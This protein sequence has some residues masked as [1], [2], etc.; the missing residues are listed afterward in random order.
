MRRTVKTKGQY[1]GGLLA[2]WRSAHGD[3]SAGCCPGRIGIN[4]NVDLLGIPMFN[5]HAVG[6]GTQET[7][8]DLPA[9]KGRSCRFETGFKAGVVVGGQ[10][11]KDFIREITENFVLGVG[12]VL[13][14]GGRNGCDRWAL[15]A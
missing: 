7:Q 6:M 1:R 12:N 14:R 4:G 2:I 15:D 3:F 10:C 5:D 13:G 8:G 11:Q 9:G